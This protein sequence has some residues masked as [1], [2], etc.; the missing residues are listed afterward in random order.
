MGGANTWLNLQ[1]R[2]GYVHL[3]CYCQ[4]EWEGKP[5][6]SW[7]RALCRAGRKVL[8]GSEGK[9]SSLQAEEEGL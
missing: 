4:E 5:K 3:R 2:E 1:G 6:H 7:M 8:K 9:S